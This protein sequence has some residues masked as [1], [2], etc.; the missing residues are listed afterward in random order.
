M[1]AC[2]SS[3]R[4]LLSAL[5]ADD[6]NLNLRAEYTHFRKILFQAALVASGNLSFLNWLTAL[7]A[8]FCF[9][10]LHLQ[11]IF[12]RKA[13][14]RALEAAAVAAM[15]VAAN[16]GGSTPNKPASHAQRAGTATLLD[17][18]GTAGRSGCP[19][20]GSTSSGDHL[21]LRR[22]K[23]DNSSALAPAAG[24]T[25]NGCT[26]DD[27]IRSRDNLER[28]EL[29]GWGRGRAVVATALR[30]AANAGMVYLVVKGSVPVVA[31]MVRRRQVM[32]TSFGRCG[33]DGMASWLA[34]LHS[35]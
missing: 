6:V 24:M 30:W 9:D 8:V 14:R 7:P 31:N 23:E 33:R 22:R 4:S 21:G 11:S 28:V 2:L 16:P 15:P 13:A 1:C 25:G 20:D 19:S 18:D 26:G 3:S 12:G 32:N 5:T 34:L 29:R 27:T 35:L 10:D 17:C